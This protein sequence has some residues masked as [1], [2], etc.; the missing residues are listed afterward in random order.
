MRD[1]W[2]II[3]IKKDDKEPA[4]KWL[5]YITKRYPKNKLSN[6]KGNLAV[7]CGKISNNL[8]IIDLDYRD[9]NKQYYKEIFGKFIKR[10]P[11]LARTYTEETPNG[12]HFFYYIK[13]DCP[14]RTLKQDTKKEKVLEKLNKQITTNFPYLLKG[15]DILGE[16]GYSLIAPS[17]INGNKYKALNNLP[18][19][20]IT[21]RTFDKILGFFL[22]DKP[23]KSYMR[24]PFVDILRGKIEIEEQALN[25]GKEEHVY[26]RYLYL[27]AY[28]F[29]HLDP[30]DIFPVLE[31][32]QPEFDLKK[33]ETQLRYVDFDDKP[34]RNDTLYEYF[35]DY[36]PKPVKKKKK[37][38]DE[39]PVWLT[40]AHNLMDKFDIITMKDSGQLM[41][42]KGNIYSFDTEDFYEALGTEIEHRTTKSYTYIKNNIIAYIK[43]MTLFDRNNFCYDKWIINFKNGYYDTTKNKFYP[44]EDFDD[45]IF[46]YEIPHEYKN[47]KKKCPAF[48]KA[49]DEW[50]GNNNNITIDDVFEMIGYTMTMNT[51]LK[52]AFFIFGGKNSGKSTFQNVLEYL[53][54][55]DN[56]SAISLQRL[57]KNEFGSHGLQFKILNMV[58]DMS[59]MEITDV[60]KFKVL[61]GGDRNVEAEVKGGNQYKFH[62]ITK[63]WYNANTIPA[64][65]ESDD[66]FFSRWLLI[67]FPNYFPLQDKS[68]I[69]NLSD[70]IC[71]NEDEIQGIIAESLKGV[72]RLFKRGYFRLDI[73]NSS[74]H[75]WRSNAEPLYAFLYDNCKR[76]EDGS[77]IVSEFRSE[78]N[79][80]LFKIGKRPLSSQKLTDYLEKF[81]IFKGRLNYVKDGK[82][83][84]IYLGIKWKEKGGI[85][86]WG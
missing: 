62:N 35:P 73:V 37:T 50:L 45:K 79:K 32:T 14:K 18:V 55:E 21:R 15:V 86:K 74:K 20:S 78:F 49:F 85:D 2:N 80:Y 19:K 22:L 58:G 51:N 54:G 60:S 25:A 63:I 13:D 38:S 44:N 82:R 64:I 12:H 27:E 29:L 1:K 84:Y 24:Q 4:I 61:T 3:P 34:M 8:V 47:G 52:M 48:K 81:N 76:D 56:R 77:I 23:I 41:I 36:K 30:E 6:H 17:S 66:A 16:N 5:D 71:E 40:I 9:N 68:T 46:C 11:R 43:D 75:V 59:A 57:S 33:T 10:F 39:E 72:K 26:W 31:Q 70:L 53:I 28:H 69:K 42:K 7:I 67:H 65:R 83:E